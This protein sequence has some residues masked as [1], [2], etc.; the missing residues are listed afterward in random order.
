MWNPTLYDFCVGEEGRGSI[1]SAAES[2]M[3]F[4]Y[5]N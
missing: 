4:N 1:E 5:F 2:E 3:P